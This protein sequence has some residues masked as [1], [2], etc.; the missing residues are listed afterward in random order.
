MCFLGWSAQSF[1]FTFCAPNKNMFWNLNK[2]VAWI[3][4]SFLFPNDL[5][6]LDRRLDGQGVHW[7]QIA[8][9]MVWTASVIFPPAEFS[10]LHG[11]NS[12]TLAP[13]HH[14]GALRARSAFQKISTF[15]LGAWHVMTIFKSIWSLKKWSHSSHCMVMILQTWKSL[16]AWICKLILLSQ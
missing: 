14:K 6:L 1:E 10:F 3:K 16:S 7:Y 11:K 2:R 9:L 15:I 8:L 4:W 13:R 5:P 12:E